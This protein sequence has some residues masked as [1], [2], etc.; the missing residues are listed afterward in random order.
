MHLYFENVATHMFRHWTGKYYPKNDERN[1]NKYTIPLKEWVE[2]SK[3]M[4]ASR[5]DMPP[6]IGRPPRSIIKY[7][8]RFKAVEWGNW[9]TL[10]S[11]PLLRG[12]LPQR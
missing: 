4:E 11:L 8:A 5:P 2:I 9:I 7:Y 10:F 6:D 12:R 3:I 1:L